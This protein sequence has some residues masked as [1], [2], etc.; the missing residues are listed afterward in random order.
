MSM[1]GYRDR[2]CPSCGGDSFRSEF[3][4]VSY[5]G[6]VRTLVCDNCGYRELR[7]TPEQEGI[8]RDRAEHP[9]RY[10]PIPP[11]DSLL[12]PLD[13]HTSRTY[14]L[15]S[16]FNGESTR[17]QEA[18]YDLKDARR[19]YEGNVC[20][21]EPRWFWTAKDGVYRDARRSLV[22][23]RPGM[24]DTVIE[25]EYIPYSPRYHVPIPWRKYTDPVKRERA[26][27]EEI[28]IRGEYADI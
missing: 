10:P 19:D 4:D 11:R 12:G 23:K 26:R 3:D 20:G 8:E 16:F 17:Y 27:Q 13:D 2:P 24:E 5:L 21:M 28:R 9:E 25:E 7:L 22:M 18:Y 15:V 6:R 1:N 14:Y